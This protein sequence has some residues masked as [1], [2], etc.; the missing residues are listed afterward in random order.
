MRE[1]VDT[2]NETKTMDSKETPGSENKKSYCKLN[3][4][5]SE[6]SQW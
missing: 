3:T 4:V 1:T 2:E 5:T 6:R